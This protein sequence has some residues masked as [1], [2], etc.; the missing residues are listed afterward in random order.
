MMPARRTG[1]AANR[2]RARRRSTSSSL[3]IAAPSRRNRRCMTLVSS[4]FS[5]SAARSAGRRSTVALTR[6]RLRGVRRLKMSRLRL[7]RARRWVSSVSPATSGSIASD[8]GAARSWRR[9]SRSR[10]A[11]AHS[12]VRLKCN[13]DSR[14]HVNGETRS[15]KWGGIMSSDTLTAAWRSVS[16]TSTPRGLGRQGEVEIRLI[17]TVVAHHERDHRP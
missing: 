7:M 16:V 5:S 6:S 4:H 8:K 15:M 3:K 10:T 11:S 9:R 13:P 17:V 12:T 1:S 2:W 14:S